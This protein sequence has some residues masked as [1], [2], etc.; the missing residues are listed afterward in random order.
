[1]PALP[2]ATKL[3]CNLLTENSAFSRAH[4]KLSFAIKGCSMNLEGNRPKLNSTISTEISRK[5]PISLRAIQRLSGDLPKIWRQSSIEE[6]VAPARSSQTTPPSISITPKPNAGGPCSDVSK[7]SFLSR[8]T[9]SSI[10]LILAA[11]AILIFS[12]TFM[13]EE[14]REHALLKEKQKKAEEIRDEI[15][16]REQSQ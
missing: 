13:A 16:E 12:L 2:R 7:E 10:P 11:T 6:P 9:K 3:W 14:N 15:N 5:R 4:G 8:V 1:M